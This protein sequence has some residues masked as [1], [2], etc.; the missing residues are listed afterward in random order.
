MILKV[1]EARCIIDMTFKITKNAFKKFND[2]VIRRKV[3]H[4]TKLP[5]SDFFPIFSNFTKAHF[6]KPNEII[7]FYQKLTVFGRFLEF[8]PVC[9]VRKSH[10]LRM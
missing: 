10:F 5:Y 2:T 9:I 4:Q 6:S 8:R 3:R 7:H 1:A